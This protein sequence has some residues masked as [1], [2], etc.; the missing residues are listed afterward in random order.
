M[1]S[2]ILVVAIVAIVGSSVPGCEAG[3]SVAAAMTGKKVK[4]VHVKVGKATITDAGSGVSHIRVECNNGLVIDADW[5]R[6]PANDFG[7]DIYEPSV[8]QDYNRLAVM[9]T[10]R[11]I[12][13]AYLRGEYD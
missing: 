4:T 5:K 12:I 6:N 7:Y 3:R 8:N 11:G 2:F 9:M 13:A 1:R 10:A